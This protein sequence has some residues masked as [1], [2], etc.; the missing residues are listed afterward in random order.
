MKSLRPFL[1]CL[2]HLLCADMAS[3]AVTV[4]REWSG[5]LAIP[6]NDPAGASRTLEVVVTGSTEILAVT[7]QLEIEGGWNGDLYAYLFHNGRLAML[8][9]RP[10][11]TLDSLQ[12]ASSSGMSVLFSDTAVPDVH[13]ALPNIGTATGVFQPDGRTSDP[14]EVLDTDPR[15]A[16]L[17]VFEGEDANGIWT[18]FLADQGPGDSSVLK[19]WSLEMTVVP[20]PDALFLIGMGSLLLAFKRP[21]RKAAA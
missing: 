1:A 6:D 2:V 9:N 19:S 18:L 8:L 13:L 10:G 5:T 21:A 16:L 12:G 20:E 4:V 7:V 14:L 3:A 17:S 11:R 15:T